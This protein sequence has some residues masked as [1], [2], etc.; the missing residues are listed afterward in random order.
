MMTKLESVPQEL[1]IFMLGQDFLPEGSLIYAVILTKVGIVVLQ[2]FN[3]VCLSYV[4][5]SRV[6]T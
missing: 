5:R 6:D 2:G 1:K 3:N 4:Y